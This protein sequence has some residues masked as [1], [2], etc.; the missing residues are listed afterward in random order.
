M[1]DPILDLD[2]RVV[3]F[4]ATGDGNYRLVVVDEN[5][6]RTVELDRAAALKLALDLARAALDATDTP[7]CPPPRKESE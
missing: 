5:G 3:D 1:T 4:S 2:G 6:T 7:P